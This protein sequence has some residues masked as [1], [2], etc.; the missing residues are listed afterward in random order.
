MAAYYL[1][2]KIQYTSSRNHFPA[3]VHSQHL[4]VAVGI[5]NIFALPCE[6]QHNYTYPSFFHR[7]HKAANG[8]TSSEDSCTSYDFAFKALGECKRRAEK[9]GMSKLEMN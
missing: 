9:A 2:I 5:C 8:V 3:C 7:N 4:N 6:T 1:L